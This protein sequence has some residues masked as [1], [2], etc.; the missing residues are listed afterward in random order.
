MVNGI[1]SI[2]A[3]DNTWRIGKYLYYGLL[4]LQHRGPDTFRVYT[5]EDNNIVERVLDSLE[6]SIFS[7]ISGH[8]GVAGAYTGSPSPDPAV[9]FETGRDSIAIIADPYRNSNDS[10]ELVAEQLLDTYKKSSSLLEAFRKVYVEAKVPVHVLAIISS[11]GELVVFRSP[12]GI[13][14]MVVG[15]YGFDMMISSSETPAI[16]II[17]GEPRRPLEPGEA[18]YVNQYLVKTEKIMY[19]PNIRLCALEPIYLCRHDSVIDGVEVYSFRKALGEALARLFDKEIDSVV[20]VPETALPYA[21]GFSQVL[22][23]KLEIGFV[24]TGTRA[25]S[26]LRQDVLD[27]VIAIQLKMNPIKSV[28]EGKRVAVIDDSLVTGATAKTIVQIL[29]NRLGAREVHLLIA[30]PKITRECPYGGP[31][32]SREELLA[33]NLDDDTI[34]KYIEADTLSWI[35]LNV[36]EETAKKHG[37][38]LCTQCLGR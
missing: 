19:S 21:V 4:A 26:A 3:F 27:K 23:K 32:A 13:K 5:I 29:R 1:I 28:F 35:P 8:I 31:I 22:G 16:E 10:L 9:L 30:S 20:G 24:A 11:R 12:P 25:R 38:H 17:G 14:P 7:E 2:Y 18:L 6:P 37:I 36:L 33:A 15:G 34:L